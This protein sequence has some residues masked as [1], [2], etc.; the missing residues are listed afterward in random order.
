[1]SLSEVTKAALKL[2]SDEQ[3]CLARAL[4]ENSETRADLT[5]D[6]AWDQEI[7]RRISALDAGLAKGR[8]FR[9]VLQDIDRR[10]RR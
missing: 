2:S 5:V 10:F 8:P 9:E 1:M 6:E 3:L 7:E 4:L